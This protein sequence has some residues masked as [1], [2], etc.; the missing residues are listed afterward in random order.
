MQLNIEM[1]KRLN[2]KRNKQ[3]LKKRVN[4]TPVSSLKA[5]LKSLR[6]IKTSFPLVRIGGPNDGGYLLPDDLTDIRACFSPGIADSASFE[7]DLANMGIP[8]FM[9]DYSV[10][11]SPIKNAAFHFQ[12]KFI[13]ISNDP[14]HITL[15]DWVKSCAPPK[16]DLI[17][18]MDIEGAEYGSLISAQLDT[19]NRFRIIV[20]E[21]HDLDN[22]F[23]KS[24][25]HFM[26][27]AFEKLLINFRVVHIHPNN[28]SQPICYGDI[29]I[30]P[31]LEFT[32]LRKDRIVKCGFID[33]LPH[34]LDASCCPDLQDFD[35]PE[36]WYKN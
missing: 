13:G 15:D 19:L 7:L 3:A 1:L 10:D 22:L 35:L 23:Y 16:E 9:T 24:S 11:D 31:L 4:L 32:F 8:S 26:K 36:C 12:K 21:F 28:Y 33:K 5:F 18:Q 25:F 30:P 17:L 2:L 6:P 34:A 27:M 20:L 14:I 29:H